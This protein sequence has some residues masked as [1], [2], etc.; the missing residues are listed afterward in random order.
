MNELKQK[1]KQ[2]PKLIAGNQ[3]ALG[4]GQVYARSSV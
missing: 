4:G 1:Q 2:K 3:P